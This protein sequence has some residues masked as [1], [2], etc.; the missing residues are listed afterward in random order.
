MLTN[1]EAGR[2]NTDRREPVAPALECLTNVGA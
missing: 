2:N 1:N